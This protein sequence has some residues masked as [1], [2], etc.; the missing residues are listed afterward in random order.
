MAK[1]IFIDGMNVIRCNL[2]LARLEETRGNDAS[3]RELLR[4]LKG[5]MERE[6]AGAEWT[7]VF[8]GALR[9]PGDKESE[10]ALTVIF[11]GERTADELIVEAA[12]DS[13]ALG[14]ETH[15][16]SNDAE[17]RCDGGRAVRSEEF[18]EELIRRPPKRKSADKGDLAGKIV[19]G[20]VR[21]G[22]LP[23]PAA[24]D[25]RL[26]SELTSTLEYFSHG[27]VQSNKLAKRLESFFRERA[28][29]SPTPDPQKTFH[30]ALKTF[31]ESI[32]DQR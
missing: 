5:L 32:K 29:V 9:G 19:A 16:V 24:G 25:A 10:G 3:R 8:D 17:V 14:H 4:L 18:Y 21:S 20:L 30:R 26:L 22:H 28:N 13:V 1:R 11:S 15:I 6:G 27:R 12:A 23:P 7:V 31:F 2:S